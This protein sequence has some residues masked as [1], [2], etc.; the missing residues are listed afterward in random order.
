MSQILDEQRTQR[1]LLSQFIHNSTM[2]LPDC[3]FEDDVA[4]VP[5]ILLLE[6]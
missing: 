2:G 3:A 4:I 6:T 5:S 1:Q